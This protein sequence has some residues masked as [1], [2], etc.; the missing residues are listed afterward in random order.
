MV[1]YAVSPC[2]VCGKPQKRMIFGMCRMC[3]RD[4]GT[5]GWTAE[6]AVA[7]I[8]RWVAEYGHPPSSQMWTRGG[9]WWPSRTTFTELFGSW[10]AGIRAAGYRS[11]GKGPVDNPRTR[12]GWAAVRRMA[13]P[14]REG[15]RRWGS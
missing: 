13:R 5:P 10:D 7:A 1:E 4:A 3:A 9:D 6:L 15:P 2:R 14:M 8:N 11:Y 12:A